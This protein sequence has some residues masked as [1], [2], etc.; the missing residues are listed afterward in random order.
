MQK[1][2]KKEYQLRAKSLVRKEQVLQNALWN[3]LGLV[4]LICAVAVLQMILSGEEGYDDSTPGRWGVFGLLIALAGFYLMEAIRLAYLLWKVR[5]IGSPAGREVSL[6][7]KRVRFLNKAVSKHSAVRICT[8]FVGEQ[9][10][11]FYEIHEDPPL[12]RFD[13]KF[14]MGKYVGRECTFLCYE[15]SGIVKKLPKPE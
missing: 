9:G 8:V 7:C 2:K 15:D 4:I 10:Q 14:Q 11:K 6:R 1:S 13:I 12:E 3:K 5:G